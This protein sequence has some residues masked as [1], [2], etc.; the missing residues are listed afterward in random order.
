[1]IPGRTKSIGL[2]RERVDVL[3]HVLLADLGW[4]GAKQWLI[5]EHDGP[6]AV[7]QG[8]KLRRQAHS[9][10]PGLILRIADDYL[11]E[12]SFLF[13]MAEVKAQPTLTGRPSLGP[14]FGCGQIVERAQLG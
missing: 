6:V 5:G 7:E 9:V 10:L 2:A 11:V 13:V 1:M 4:D 8:S 3:A 14:L 12:H